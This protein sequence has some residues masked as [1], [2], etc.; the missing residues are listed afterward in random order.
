[1]ANIS[2]DQETFERD[3]KNFQCC[4]DD[5]VVL[6]SNERETML[7][8]ICMQSVTSQVLYWKKKRSRKVN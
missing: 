4:S 1:M 2:G 5:F 7:H 3:P 8:V 6:R